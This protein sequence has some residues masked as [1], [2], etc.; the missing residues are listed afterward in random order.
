VRAEH[1]VVR[2]EDAENGIAVIHIEGAVV[3]NLGNTLA[4]SLV[5]SV[6]AEAS[7]PKI[8]L[9]VAGVSYLDSFSFGWI[10]KVFK[11]IREKKGDFAICCP[12]NDV[13]YLFEI[14]DF[15][16]IIPAYRTEQDA[17]EAIATGNQGKRIAHI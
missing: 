3:T 9:N 14:T 4:D 10:M 17:Q 7:P 13:L 11:E 6:L 15:T 8:I 2:K 12:N 1:V 5:H 16:R